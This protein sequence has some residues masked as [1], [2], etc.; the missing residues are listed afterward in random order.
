ML[1]KLKEID[2][3]LEAVKLNQEESNNLHRCIANTKIEIVVH[4]TC[5]LRI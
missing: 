1:Q 4:R 3:T 2:Q 5:M